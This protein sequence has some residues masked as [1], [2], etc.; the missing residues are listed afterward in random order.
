MWRLQLYTSLPTL[1]FF[2]T[3]TLVGVKWSP[4]AF[5]IL[6]FTFKSTIHFKLI[7]VYSIR[8]ES[9]FSL[10]NYLKTFLSS[11]NYLTSF[12]KFQLT[13]N[14]RIHFCTLNSV[15]LKGMS[16]LRPNTVLITIAFGKFWNWEVWLFKLRSFPRLFWLFWVACISVWILGSAYQF[17]Q[18]KAAG[19]I[20]GIAKCV[21]QFGGIAI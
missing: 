4:H 7:F 8:K 19:K 10:L 3:A 20:I 18:K 12:I 16:I 21:G 6:V 5:I 17:L 11:L 14:V 9:K 2:I 13:I 1:V 15:P